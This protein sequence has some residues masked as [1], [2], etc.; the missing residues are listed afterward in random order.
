MNKKETKIPD[1]MEKVDMDKLDE[2]MKLMQPLPCEIKMH[3]PLFLDYL[4]KPMKFWEEKYIEDQCKP[5]LV[6]GDRTVS[7]YEVALQICKYFDDDFTVDKNVFYNIEN[8]FQ[9]LNK[10]AS[11]LIP[12][13]T[14]SMP[15]IQT[16]TGLTKA[17]SMLQS[18]LDVARVRQNIFCFG[19]SGT[20]KNLDKL[21]LDYIFHV[22]L[23]QKTLSDYHVV[24]H[25]HFQVPVTPNDIARPPTFDNTEELVEFKEKL[26][27]HVSVY[28]SKYPRCDESSMRMFE[29]HRKAH[30]EKLMEVD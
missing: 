16:K 15:Y 21:L 12:S 13:V 18:V 7:K 4:N 26:Q 30:L 8:L 6:L 9:S 1:W 23:V 24:E 17:Y 19:S 20:L 14:S 29:Q 22:V 11:Y 3:K 5:I 28:V 2:V 25:F 27:E 10:E